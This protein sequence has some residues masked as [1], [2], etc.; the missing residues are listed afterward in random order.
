LFLKL[1]KKTFY[2][3]ISE[4]KHIKRAKPSKVGSTQNKNLCI[5]VYLLCGGS[6]EMEDVLDKLFIW[7]TTSISNNM[8]SEDFN[9]R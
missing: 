7:E 1:D 2:F 3:Q 6:N 8:F 5:E 4:I 9:P